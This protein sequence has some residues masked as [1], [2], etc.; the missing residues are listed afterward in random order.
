MSKILPLKY[1][2]TNDVLSLSQDLLGKFL[3]TCINGK[4][5]GGMIVETEAYR[6]PEDRASHAFGN[7]RTKRNEAMYLAGGVSYV[8]RCYGI[9]SLFNIVTNIENIPHAILVRAIEPIEGIEEML[10]RRNKE[11]LERTLTAGPGALAQALGID[12]MHNCLPLT[13]KIIWIEDRGIKIDLNDIVAGPRIGVDY[14]GEDAL[15]PWRYRIKNNSWTS[16][17]RK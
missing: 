14:A 9:H 7:R 4:R 13:G 12:I 3:M 5:T 17:N 8:Y 2:Q 15:L 1:Y 6:A 16:G 11:R 10:L